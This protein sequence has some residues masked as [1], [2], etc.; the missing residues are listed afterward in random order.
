MRGEGD[1]RPEWGFGDAY[2]RF[3]DLDL[4]QDYFLVCHGDHRLAAQVFEPAG[5]PRGSAVVVHGYYDHVGLYGHLIRYLLGTGR[6]VLA[7]DQQGHGLSTGAAATIE[8]FDHYA[9]AF[10]TVL[11]IAQPHLCEPVCVVAQSMGAAVVMQYGKRPGSRTF[12]GTALL[13]PLVRPTNWRWNR[14]V[15]MVAKR[16]VASVGRGWVNNTENP[17]FIELLRRDPLQCRRLPVQWVTAMVE[18]MY[19]FETSEPLPLRPLVVQGG[20]DM[21]VD[22]TYNIPVLQRIYDV[23]LL[24]IPEARHHLVNETEAIRR[25]MWRFFD[26][27][28]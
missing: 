11:D 13:A 5:P 26:A 8:S 22:G 3:Y 10:E 17:E 16:T 15:Y 12:E 6:R 23:E 7:Y 19:R 25:Q 27:R 18:W 9:D 20:R 4:G 21:T 24:E 1:Y 28:L 14:F 2:R